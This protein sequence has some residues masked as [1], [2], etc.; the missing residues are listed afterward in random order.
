MRKGG[1][2]LVAIV[3]SF[4]ALSSASLGKILPLIPDIASA[5]AISPVQASWLISVIPLV[6]VL[7]APIAGALG[8]RYGDR[9]L[10]AA[11]LIS[12]MA[13][14][15]VD[16]LSASYAG[17]MVGRGI[18]GFG[19][20]F[21]L[22]GAV[23]IM[24]RLREGPALGAAMAMFGA[25]VPAGVGIAEALA[26]P[27]AGGNWRLVFWGHCVFLAADL[28]A[29]R[30]LPAWQPGMS[31]RQRGGDPLAIYRHS[32]PVRLSLCL[33]LMTLAQFGISAIFPAYLHGAYG[34]SLGVA[35]LMGALGLAAGLVGNVGSSTLLGRGVDAR[36]LAIFGLAAFAV[37][38]VLTFT[39]GLGATAAIVD[40]VIFL[41]A[42]GF[43]NGL[44]LAMLPRV[45]P[46]PDLRARASG[47]T[48]QFNNMGLLLGPPVMFAV[49]AG[50]G[51]IGV[52]ATALLCALAAF[53]LMP[54]A[55][56]GV[57]P[58]A[59]EAH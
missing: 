30:A 32:R 29:V 56:A 2:G 41:M 47:L 11:G 23:A 44:F 9:A 20:V 26:G 48:N 37:F 8:D 54:L 53:A 17:L 40:S 49:V 5:L 34:L 22:T 25:A 15:V 52:L 1:W 31:H 12:M 18:E 14:N 19:F 28:L 27:V 10:I 55:R 24:M 21:T 39:R 51:G 50:L 36:R 3:C 13:G 4:A 57:R 45:L 6:A 43:T 7:A 58:D 35:A 59:I 16:A 46:D 42:G 38:G 33:C